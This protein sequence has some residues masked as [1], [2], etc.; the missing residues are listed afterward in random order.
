[1]HYERTNSREAHR[2]GY[3]TRTLKTRYGTLQL[4]KP[5]LREFPFQTQVFDRYSRVEKAL[6]N[7]IVESYIQGV[8]TRRV[9]EIINTLGGEEISPQS[10]SKMAKELDGKV[11][12]FLNRPI[13]KEVPYLFVDASYY[14][15][16]DEEAGRYKTKALL[17]VVGIKEDGYREILG[18]KPVE[19]EGEAFWAELFE[20]LKKRGLRGVKLV[21][22]DGHKGIKAAAEKAFLG[23]SWQMCHVHLERDV[24]SKVPRKRC[25]EISQR[26][27]NKSVG[28]C[29]RDA[30]AYRGVRRRRINKNCIC[31]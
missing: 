12:E 23:A 21:T 18:L 28:K 17:I 31:V 3:R 11:Q 5:Q 24:L 20:E 25:E 30:E 8:S 27:D 10:V 15:V 9:K 26:I 19:N 2:N 29:G 7:V 22:S 4:L 1:M 14:K 6:Q 13:E 16:R